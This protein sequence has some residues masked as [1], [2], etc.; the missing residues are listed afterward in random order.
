MISVSLSLSLDDTNI[1][2]YNIEA[3][4]S[5][6]RGKIFRLF[7]VDSGGRFKGRIAHCALSSS[8]T[9]LYVLVCRYNTDTNYGQTDI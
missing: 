6:T 4:D 1:N 9:L 7:S 5:K 3:I 8:H 2:Q